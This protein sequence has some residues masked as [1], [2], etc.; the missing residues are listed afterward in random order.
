MFSASPNK[1]QATTIDIMQLSSAL[2]LALATAVSAAPK[3]IPAASAISSP[4]EKHG[5]SYALTMGPLTFLYPE[6]REWTAD[7]DNTAPCGSTAGVSSN[8]SEFPLDDG[9]VAFIAK[10]VS[11]NVKLSI[12]Y[13]SNPTSQDDF[14]E[15]YYGKN[16][17]SELHIG[18]TCF[19][20]PDQP[21]N[22]GVGDVATIQAIYMNDDE[23]DESNSDGSPI[24]SGLNETFYF[25]SD[26]K[27]VEES[28]FDVTDY[29]YSCFNA[30]NDDYYS[31]SSVDAATSSATYD[32][33]VLSK[34]ASVQSSAGTTATALTTTSTAASSSTSSSKSKGDAGALELPLTGLAA[35]AVAIVGGLL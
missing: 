27:F 33:S 21:S 26:I 6:V 23:D 2:L 8:R 22:I 24:S 12:S 31:E 1:F 4:D 16:V 3:A 29:A 35:A 34:V 14:D 18:H 10:Y 20:M 9:F 11:Y 28:V 5:S 13:N 25:C 15:W 17:S 7:A 32:S 19:Y 30:T